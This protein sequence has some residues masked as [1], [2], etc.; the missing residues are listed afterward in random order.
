MGG[1]YSQADID[2]L[3][4]LWKDI[5]EGTKGG[6]AVFLDTHSKSNEAGQN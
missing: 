3:L 1:I 4:M 2:S 5:Y 6:E